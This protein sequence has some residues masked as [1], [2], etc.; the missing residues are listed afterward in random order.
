MIR[1]RFIARQFIL[2]LAVAMFFGQMMT[3][4]HAHEASEHSPI[5]TSCEVCILAVN[6]KGDFSVEIDQ[7]ADTTDS[8][9]WWVQLDR[10]ALPATAPVPSMTY[11]IRLTDPPPD[12]D[13]RPDSARAPPIYI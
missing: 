13:L 11:A 7:N 5:H 3:V 6:D 8:V 12:P 10:L 1:Q 9:I 4:S 2:F